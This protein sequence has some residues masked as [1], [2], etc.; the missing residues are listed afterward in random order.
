MA[1]LAGDLTLSLQW[2]RFNLWPWNFHM[3]WEPP[4]FSYLPNTWNSVIG[5]G[6]PDP[7]HGSPVLMEQSY[8]P[9]LC[10]DPKAEGQSHVGGVHAPSHCKLGGMKAGRTLGLGSRARTVSPGGMKR[11]W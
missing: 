10:Q 6:R 2:L 7:L 11:A 1:Q 9:A 8:H 5:L 3:P 4:K